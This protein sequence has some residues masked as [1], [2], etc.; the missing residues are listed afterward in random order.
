M[1]TPDDSMAIVPAANGK[2]VSLQSGSPALYALVS[3]S[4]STGVEKAPP[5]I[6]SSTPPPLPTG[7]L[8]IPY[9]YL[10]LATY[11]LLLT[12]YYLLLTTYD[13]LLTTYY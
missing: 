13:L 7:H 12:T 4:T 3:D 6:R 9:Y 1:A 11:Y 8:W 2:A 5:P 10:L